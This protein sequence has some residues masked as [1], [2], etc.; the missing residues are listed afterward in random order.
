MAEIVLFHHALGLTGGCVAFADDLRA[1]GH[2]VHTR[3]LYD[4]LTFTDLAEGVA[5]ARRIGFGAVVER[6]RAAVDDL[7]G[8]GSGTLVF[9]GFSL[10]VM[11][12]QLLA[13][14]SSRARG[15]LFFHGCLPPAEFGTGWPTG[16]PLQI[17]TMDDDE[18]GDVD[19]ARELASSVPEAELFLY[20]GDRHLFTDPGLPGYDPQATA[21]AKD[22]VLGFLA[23]VPS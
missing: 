17:H 3:D 5:Y 19:V 21:L 14:T 1:A 6:G 15:A 13:Q 20:P 12:A 16:V 9:A 23:T 2:V 11:P 8:E 10:G 22:R 7:P 4:G 18:L